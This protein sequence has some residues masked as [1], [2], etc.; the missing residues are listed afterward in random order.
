[1]PG[2]VSRSKYLSCSPP[3]LVYRNGNTGN[4]RANI[5]LDR[6]GESLASL[7]RSILS[8]APSTPLGR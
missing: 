3:L 4:R 5:V 2:L 1:M 8:F 6:R 7:D